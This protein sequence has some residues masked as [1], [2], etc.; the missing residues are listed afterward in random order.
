MNKNIPAA[1][2]I[3]PFIILTIYMIWGSQIRSWILKK[4]DNQADTPPT[5]HSDPINLNTIT[6]EINLREINADIKTDDNKGLGYTGQNKIA[7]DSKGNIYITYRNK[8]EGRYEIFVAKF[9]KDQNLIFNKA[10]TKYES[11]Q[12]VPSLTIDYEDN[13]HIVWYGLDPQQENLGR[14]IKYTKS[15][16]K[17]ETWSTPQNIGPVE[18]YKNEDYW[19][20]HPHISS[21]KKNL[22]VVWEG[23]DNENPN[24]QIKFASSNDS[25]EN[26][27]TWKN[28]YVT[29]GDSQSRPTVI[30]D[31][32]GVINLFFYSGYET[33]NSQIRYAYSKDEGA[34]WSTPVLLSKNQS[35]DARH[36]A[37]AYL[38]DKIIAVWR[39]GPRDKDA[40]G[41]NIYYSI[42]D[43]NQWT[44]PQPITPSVS[45]YKF[46]PSITTN[47]STAIISWMQTP[48][49]SDF[50]NEDPEGGD[51]YITKID[52]NQLVI[53]EPILIDTES[54]YSN[55][56]LDVERNV[57]FL[58]YEKGLSE[59]FP[60]KIK[61][62]KFE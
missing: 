42:L 60:I 19:Q 37:A 6:S 28:I 57:F 11:T 44:A 46:F 48:K 8:N 43:S 53:K 25:G 49:Y 55:L 32:K 16:D 30:V 1:I 10:I 2:L 5:E 26:W 17:G 62:G 51:L 15:T 13:I 14:Q 35:N 9:D 29:K 31:S 34:T 41:T 47:G 38:K 18:G 54:S 33:E 22:Y 59:P 61:F 39:E 24:Q 40:G 20:E 45:E 36:I 12:R 4:I 7:L 56:S 21:F 50:P 58:L 23:K 27:S 3:T 52:L